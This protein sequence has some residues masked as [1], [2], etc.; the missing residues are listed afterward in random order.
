MSIDLSECTDTHT[1]T[2]HWIWLAT[3][4]E[5]HFFCISMSL[6]QQCKYVFVW[7]SIFTDFF[8][9]KNANGFLLHGALKM[10]KKCNKEL[11]HR[12]ATKLHAFIWYDNIL[13]SWSQNAENKTSEANGRPIIFGKI[14]L[15]SYSFLYKKRKIILLLWY[16][17]QYDVILLPLQCSFPKLHFFHI[18]AHNVRKGTLCPYHVT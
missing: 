5:E 15:K 6:H 3:V 8:V 10:E 16:K 17:N 2:N 14:F 1:H 18:L 9:L 7:V 13:F 12:L 11:L 4:S